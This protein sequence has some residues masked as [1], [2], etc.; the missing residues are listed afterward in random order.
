MHVCLPD[1]LGTNWGPMD[2]VLFM[3]IR[4]AKTLP[5]VLHHHVIMLC[6]NNKT[7]QAKGGSPRLIGTACFA[8]APGVSVKLHAKLLGCRTVLQHSVEQ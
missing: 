6:G 3:P 5:G 7:G 8:H 4:L 2:R 1:V